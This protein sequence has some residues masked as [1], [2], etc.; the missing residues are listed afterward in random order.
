M[1]YAS[2]SSRSLGGRS[3]PFIGHRHQ[4]L[5]LDRALLMELDVKPFPLIPFPRCLDQERYVVVAL[6]Q[7]ETDR[8]DGQILGIIS[9]RIK[10]VPQV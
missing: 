7:G 8:P 2:A 10:L 6:L 5:T 3:P 9:G 1:Q 4:R